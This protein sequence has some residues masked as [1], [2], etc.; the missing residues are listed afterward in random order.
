MTAI[1]RKF[2]MEKPTHDGKPR[3]NFISDHL[4]IDD[5]LRIT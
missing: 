5:I 3:I 2:R 4:Q 1:S